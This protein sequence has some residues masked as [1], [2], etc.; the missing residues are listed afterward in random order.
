ME[1]KDREAPCVLV[2]DSDIL[3]R[4]AIAD[5]LRHCGYGVIEAA[6]SEEVTTIL[7]TDRFPVQ[8]LLCDARINGA[9]TGLELRAWAARHRPALRVALA[10]SLEKTAALAAELC[11]EGPQLS[12]PYDPQMVVDHIKRLLAAD[13]GPRRVT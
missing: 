13:P 1:D 2:A 5:Y 3:E 11:D 9:M 4:H 7:E 12:R 8:V 10:A 6:S